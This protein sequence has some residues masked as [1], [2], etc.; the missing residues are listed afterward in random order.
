MIISPQDER[1]LAATR[2]KNAKENNLLRLKG[3]QV[4]AGSLL[5]GAEAR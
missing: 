4:E 1:L 5:A 3:K 2:E